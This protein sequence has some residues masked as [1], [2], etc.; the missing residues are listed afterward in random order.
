MVGSHEEYVPLPLMRA[1]ADAA[2][3]AGDSVRVLFIPGAG[4]FEVASP[5]ASTWPQVN[6]AIRSLIDGRL[7]P[8]EPEAAP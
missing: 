4:H 3:R 8:A 6:A 2:H 5:R 1:D 7:P